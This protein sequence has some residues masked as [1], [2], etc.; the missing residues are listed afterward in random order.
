MKKIST[1]LLL[2]VILLAAESFTPKP[3]ADK[4]GSGYNF[5]VDGGAFEAKA[6][7]NYSAQ[8]TNGARTAS[9]TLQGNEVT[10][11]QGH[12]YP[13]SIQIDYTFK[14][15]VPGEVNVE[16]ISY[17]YNNQRYN[18]LPGTAYM[19]ITKMKW[20]ADKKSFTVCADVFCKVQKP[21]VMEE[22]VPVFI[23]RGQLQNLV[24]NAPVM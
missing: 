11:K 8:L 20:S 18:M 10:D 9:I 16:G 7:N 12:S 22:N 14:D 15:G 2:A 17:K 3:A 5:T 23:I 19:S 1:I 24:V 21:Y 4:A 6:T 13:S